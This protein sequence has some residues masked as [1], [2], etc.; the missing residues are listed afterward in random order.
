MIDQFQIDSIFYVATNK[1]FI[2][3]FIVIDFVA[4]D[5]RRETWIRKV[6][7]LRKFMKQ[8]EKKRLEKNEN[9]FAIRKQFFR[10]VNFIEILENIAR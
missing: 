6:F 5:A 7:S 2:Q 3:T 4:N 8:R 9:I 1:I 10:L